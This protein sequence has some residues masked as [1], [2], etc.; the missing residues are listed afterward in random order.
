MQARADTSAGTC[1]GVRPRDTSGGGR[2]WSPLDAA[3]AFGNDCGS[4]RKTITQTISSTATIKEVA[5]AAGVSVATVSHVLNETRYVSPELARRVREAMDELGYTPNST[6]RSLRVRKTQTIGLVVPDVNP[7]FAELARIIEDHGFASGYTT[8]LGNT[9]GHPDRERRYLDTLISKQVDG[10]ILASTLHDAGGLERLVE[11]SGTP[12]VLVDRDVDFAGVDIVLAD[13]LGGG[14]AATRHLLDLGH[15]QIACITGPSQLTPSADRTTGYRRALEEAGIDPNPDWILRG[16]L[17]YS[18]G[19]KAMRAL[20][21]AG[22][23]VTA[24]FAANDLM[25]IG[26]M[27]ELSARGTSVPA[28]FSIAGFDDAFPAALVS[29]SLTTV[30]Q[31]LLEMGSTAVQL[32]LARIDGA[33][34]ER[35]ERRLLPTE[36]VVRESTAALAGERVVA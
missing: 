18:G 10:L 2:A 29:P 9:D 12:V 17:H 5:H 3:R 4:L 34:P 13:N 14:Y 24:V 11:R 32:L 19:R 6:A 27:G 30:R 22:A 16:D 35:P 23:P 1:R 28:Q 31:P 7:F 8:I 15:T 26:A 21:D 20:L 25:A 36:L 33:A